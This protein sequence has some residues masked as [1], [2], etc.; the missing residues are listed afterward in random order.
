MAASRDEFKV[1]DSGGDRERQ[2]ARSE[3]G[4]LE[5]QRRRRNNVPLFEDAIN[6][7]RGNALTYLLHRVRAETLKDNIEYFSSMPLL[8]DINI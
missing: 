7:N 3:E 4:P 5:R 2:R 8:G 1:D 6:T